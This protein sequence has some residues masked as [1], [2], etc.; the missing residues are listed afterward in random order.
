MVGLF[1]KVLN[2]FN[3]HS[4]YS[5]LTEHEYLEKHFIRIFPKNCFACPSHQGTQH[6][7]QINFFHMFVYCYLISESSQNIYISLI[8][9]YI[10]SRKKLTIINEVVNKKSLRSPVLVHTDQDTFTS[11]AN[12]FL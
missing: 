7:I 8:N 12:Q 11:R 4:D 2:N 1:R 5:Y 10:G 6:L 9:M 3:S